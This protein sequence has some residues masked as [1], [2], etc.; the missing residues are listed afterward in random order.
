MLWGISEQWWMQIWSGVIGACVAAIVSVVVALLVVNRTNAHQTSL[1]ATAREE[2]RELND[3][4]LEVQRAGFREQLAEQ[5][6]ESSRLRMMEIRADVVS[7]AANVTEAGSQSPD[8]IAQASRLLERAITR[9]RIE[10]EDKDLIAEL[11]HWPNHIRFLAGDYHVSLKDSDAARMVS[12]DKFNEAVSLLSIVALHLPRPAFVPPENLCEILKK[13]RE[14]T[15]R[16]AS[17][18]GSSTS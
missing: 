6:K 3:K 2:Q 9:W 13:G 10:S 15:L 5:R 11:M 7:A 14:G 16:T 18:P 1:A 8:A 17:R 12:F 4:A